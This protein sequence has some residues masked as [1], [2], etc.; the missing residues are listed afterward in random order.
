MLNASK[1]EE[2]MMMAGSITAAN[3]PITN[4]T[5]PTPIV[6]PQPGDTQ[7][8][9]GLDPFTSLDGQLQKIKQDH[10]GAL[11]AVNDQLL[12]TQIELTMTKS[13]LETRTKERDQ[14]ERIALKFITQFDMVAKIFAEVQ[15]LALAHG[16]INDNGVQPYTLKPPGTQPSPFVIDG[17]QAPEPTHD[18][19][20]QNPATSK[21]YDASITEPFAWVERAPTIEFEPPLAVALDGRN[22]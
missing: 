14:S 18:A 1:P 2:K 10:D 7:P 22:G 9:S 12:A 20:W 16:N 15:A 21:W 6:Q 11:K 3:S 4:V 17:V 19:S 8:M 5:K 13:A